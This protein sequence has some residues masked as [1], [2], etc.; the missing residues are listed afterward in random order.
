MK[1]SS[2]ELEKYLHE[3]QEYITELSE[4]LGHPKEQQRVMIIWRAVMRAIRDRIQMSE[5][6]DLISP[7][8]M[9]LKGIYTMGWKYHETPPYDYTTMEEM[10]SRVKTLQEQYGETEFSWNKSTEEII[11]IVLD[12]LERYFSEGQMDH[13]RTQLPE[14]VEEV[15]V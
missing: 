12:S 3:T 4:D 14:E 9:I 8:P 10:K 13:I 11:S 15:L 1:Y 2:L 7:L 5:S 6:L